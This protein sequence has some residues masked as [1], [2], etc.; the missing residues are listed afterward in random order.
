MN[1]LPNMVPERE[2]KKNEGVFQKHPD[3]VDTFWLPDIPN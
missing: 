3:S 1:N 2:S